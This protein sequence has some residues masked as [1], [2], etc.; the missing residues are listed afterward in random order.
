MHLQPCQ[1]Y[2]KSASS[3]RDTS[4][5]NPR[6]VQCR[7]PTEWAPGR[8][9]L[10]RATVSMRRAGRLGWLAQRAKAVSSRIES[11]RVMMAGMGAGVSV[12]SNECRG[13]FTK[14]RPSAFWRPSV[15][16]VLSLHWRLLAQS[17]ALPKTQRR[18]PA[19]FPPHGT[20]LAPQPTPYPHASPPRLS[21]GEPRA[22]PRRW[23][24][25]PSAGSP[26][27]ARPH[28][29]CHRPAH[30]PCA[31]RYAAQALLHLRAF[32]AVTGADGAG[33][34]WY[35][36]AKPPVRPIAAAVHID[37]PRICGSLAVPAKYPKGMERIVVTAIVW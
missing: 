8:N 28:V 18:S 13:D 25:T 31:P 24:R 20:T 32:V 17:G 3:T 4:R 1:P 14:L 35:A 10:R 27:P 22:P 37:G 23:G 9:T 33:G 15:G 11:D 7:D 16:S 21:R 29:A 30:S 6:P 5:A 36:I 34:A 12:D 2:E 19:P 26:T